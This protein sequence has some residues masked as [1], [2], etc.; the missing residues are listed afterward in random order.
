MVR[1][2]SRSDNRSR[3]RGRSRV[4]GRRS[5][6]SRRDSRCESI[7]RDYD[8]PRP[9]SSDRGRQAFRNGSHD[10]HRRSPSV[11]TPR[12][13]RSRDRLALSNRDRRRPRSSDRPRERNRDRHV[14]RQRTRDRSESQI[15]SQ[16]PGVTR[17]NRARQLRSNTPRTP[18]PTFSRASQM[19]D[20]AKETSAPCSEASTLAHALM[21]AIKTMQPPRLHSQHYYVSNFD[22]TINNFDTWCEEVDRARDANNWSDHECLSRVATGLKGDAKVWLSEWV[23]NDRTWTNFKQEFKP[24]CPTKLDFANIL[25]DAMNTTSDKYSTYAEYARRTLLRLRVIRGISDELRTLIVIRG[26]DNPQIRAA[27]ANADLTPDTLVSFLSIYTKP[28]R[29]RL[30]TNRPSN[31]KKRPP[32]NSNVR[33]ELKCFNCSQRGHLSRDCRQPKTTKTPNVQTTPSK[34]CTFC[35]KQ[36][37]TED[38]CFTKMRSETRNQRNVNLCS[39]QPDTPQNS[40]ITTAVIDGIP[41][42][43]LIDSGAL[44]VSL[45]SSDVLKYITCQ[46]KP[47][48]CVLKGISEKEIVS[49]SYVTATVE[50]SDIAIEVDLVVVPSP[51]MNAPIIIGTDVLNQD[52]ITFVRTKDRQYLTRSDESHVHVNA[53]RRDRSGVNTALEGVELEKLMSVI[54]EFSEFLISGTAATTVKTGEMD[55]RLT[56]PT[57]VVYRPYKLSY[58]E[59]LKVR[60]ITKDLLDKGVIRRSQS[61]YASPIILVK[62]RDGTDRLC[63]DYRALNRIT[64]KDRYPLPL[65]DDH[66]D[67]LGSYKY[68]SSLD[69]ATGFHQIPLKEECIHLTGFVTPEDH[70]EYLKMPYGLANSPIVYQR[71][72]NDTLRKLI[73]EGNV[74][75]YVDD[76]LLLSN[77]IDEGLELLRR[78]LGTLTQAGFSVNLKKCSFLVT[79]VEY[80]G[81]VVSEG[82]VR[83]S[84]R[85]IEALVNTL[86]PENVKQV[87]QLLGLAGYFRRYIKDYALLTA[88]IAHLTKKGVTFNWTPECEAIRQSLIGKLTDEPVLMIFDPHLP[89]ELHT[90]ASSAGYGAVLLQAH[91]DGKKH[92]IAYYSKVTQ[93]AEK[94]Y[95]SY[96]LETLAVVKALQ[97]FR[98]YLVGLKFKVVTD[99]NALKST[100]RKKDLLPRVARWWIYLQDFEFSIE[101]RKG[102]MMPH[103]DYLSRNPVPSVNQV[104]RPRNWAQ[105]AQAADNETQDLRQ[106]LQDGD[107]DPSRYVVQNDLLY[108]KYTPVGNEPR[109]LCYI[110][111]GH[112]LSLLR[113]FHD[114]HEH[115]G[116][117]K[118]LDLILKHFWFPGLKQFVV[119]YVGHCL[120][121]I[122]KKRVPRAPLQNITS[123]EK[124][125]IPF[126]TLHMDALGPLPVCD[127]YKFVLVTV[128]AFTKFS[129]LHPMYRQDTSEL[130]RIVTQVV[131]LFGVPK[132]LVTDKG[133]M[134]ESSD[135]VTW[136]SELGCDLHCVTPE[137]HHANGQVERYVRTVLNMLRIEVNQKNAS[138]PETLWKLQLV[139]NITKQKTTQTSP[140]NLLIGTEATTPAIRGLVRD[141]AMEGSTSNRES[142]REVARSRSRQL[143]KENQDKQDERVNRQ[144][145]PP[146]K[147]NVNDHVFVIKFSQSTGKLDPGMRGPYKVIKAL[148]GG[149]YELRLL[150]G[151]YGKTTQAAAQFMVPWRGEWCPATC[152]AFFEGEWC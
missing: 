132:L 141:L 33:T 54:E 63:V 108:Y 16:S 120:V 10:R 126:H 80:L 86:P 82:Q 57:P 133:R 32:V 75:V 90:D 96:E 88:P 91:P 71:I 115:I 3:A 7:E 76:V 18:S 84:P 92:V 89:T 109:L 12:R 30:N 127:G 93:G 35:K 101:Y 97:N 103:A 24:L 38:V 66:I 5:S 61:E 142:L 114:E 15:R 68:F 37:H 62:K 140:L 9:G 112:R 17:R 34:T 22:P 48:R 139:L 135:F 152:A 138:W 45:I 47:K 129:L 81:R 53:A 25:F 8:N 39:Y 21:E 70:F 130:K 98:H 128:D 49:T 41:V 95:H 123:W 78:V 55:I 19:P 131:S 2:R 4:R 79:E 77:T 1:S 26:I 146:R 83:P 27:A 69:M 52:G 65:I 121:C 110:P 11:R 100:E 73:N 23:T 6:R 144:R 119:K 145:Q 29:D 58:Q 105:I 116:V 31:N 150:T 122:S 94:R 104:S 43:V 14:R 60:D 20:H 46:P 118:T 136:V 134:F 148:P 125:D 107:L 59:K 51:Y 117:E 42:D 111:K 56:S 87:R 28:N 67:R 143:L 50:F 72:I 106:K 36:G 99:C 113:I 124:P 64:V 147:F 74:L 102:V 40:D 137:M 85:K 151:G 13:S 149:R 44:G